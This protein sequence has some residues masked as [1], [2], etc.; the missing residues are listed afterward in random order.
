MSLM[1]TLINPMQYVAISIN[2]ISH[3]VIF[4]GGAYIALHSRQIPIW[5]RTPLWYVG[6]SS[7][8]TAITILFQWVLGDEFPLSYSNIGL[9][10]EIMLNVNLSIAVALMFFSTISKDI[11]GYKSRRLD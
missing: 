7:L 11:K 8:L 2:F 6:A 9:F 4:L 1:S 10:C 3:L 5:L